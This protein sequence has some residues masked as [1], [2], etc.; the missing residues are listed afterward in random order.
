LPPS[1]SDETDSAAVEGPRPPDD[2]I[3]VRMVLAYDGSGFHGFA[4]Q[5]GQRTVAGELARAISKF[6][7]HGVELVCAGR[8]DSGV[9]A[10]GQVVH[11]DLAPSVDLDDLKRSVNRQLA[12]AIV[13]RSVE[14]AP[15]G[16]DAR[17]S[18]LSRSYRYL[19]FQAAEPDPLLSTA[20]WHVPDPLDLRMMRAAS[21]GLIGEHDFSAF[22]RKPPGHPEGAPITRR[23]VDANW[24]TASYL[25]GEPEVSE[26]LLRFD[27]TASSF[28]H[29][30]VRSVVG[31]L[32]EIG[33]GRM[34]PS[35]VRRLLESGDRAG[36]K[37]LAPA[38]GL[39]LMSV[40]Y[41]D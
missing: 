20:A 15:A 36:A 16:F 10:H 17:R 13:L 9:H 21:D 40:S 2:A 7:R 25:N 4:R 30:M 5:P 12:P 14:P 41:A 26:R 18:A 6:S 31:V 29:Q 1:G 27:I 34:K 35:D 8:T 22:C 28:C 24:S 32:V 39:C 33:R 37:T 19:V 3:R 38:H 23:V 11:T